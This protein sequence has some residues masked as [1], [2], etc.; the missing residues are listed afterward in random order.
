MSKEEFN[1]KYASPKFYWGTKPSNLTRNFA[2][3]ANTGPALDLGMGE[4]RDAIFLAQKGFDVIG[5]DNSEK[6][7]EKCRSRAE[8][9]GVD[10]KT[11]LEDVRH[12]KI[13][14]NKYTLTLSNNLFQFITKSEAHQVSR[15]IIDGLR[16]GGLVIAS[17][18]TYD[19][20]RYKEYKKKTTELEPGTFLM[21]NGDMY[22][23]Y[24]YRELLELF[25]SLR[26][27]YYAEYDYY[28]TTHGEGHWHGIAELVAKKQ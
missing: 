25:T 3:L 6:G 27:L 7:I 24:D 13:A 18:L 19:D 5:V 2:P 4:G 8:K 21:V 11:K 12:F 28:D 9:V 26:L 16:K 14:K 1:E 17:V 20:P 22:S 10:V 15:N 23:F